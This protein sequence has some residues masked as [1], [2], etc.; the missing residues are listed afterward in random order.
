MSNRISDQPEER[1]LDELAIK[2]FQDEITP[3]EYL[4]KYNA[5]MDKYS[6]QMAEKWQYK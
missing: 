4:K 1:E 2:L 5:F 6:S 3:E